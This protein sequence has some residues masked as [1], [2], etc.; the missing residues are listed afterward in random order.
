MSTT[1]TITSQSFLYDGPIR[2]RPII[3]QVLV[4]NVTKSSPVFDPKKHLRYVAPERIF[5][6]TDVGYPEG[7]GISPNAISEGFPLF[8]QEAIEIMR[9]EIFSDDV[10]SNCLFVAG[11]ST[12]STIRGHCP[13]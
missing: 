4:E 7:T 3:N 12:A 11:N 6:M 5:S 8:T 9:S 10:W 13:K 1:E 2:Y